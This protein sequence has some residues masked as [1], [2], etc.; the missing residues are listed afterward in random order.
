[1]FIVSYLL[2]P[3]NMTIKDY[4]DILG[5]PCNSGI[6][7]IKK[8][9]R[10]KAHQYHPDINHSPGAKDKF[11]SVTEAYEFLV[12]YSDKLASDERAYQQAMEDWR[13][14][15]QDRS[16]M[17]ASS[18]AHASYS[19]FRKTKLYKTTRIFDGTRII[20]SLV[21]SVLV[22]AYSIYGYIYRLHHPWN[23]EKPSVLAFILLLGVGFIFLSFS[24]LYLLSWIRMSKKR[25]KRSGTSIE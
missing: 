15:R 8:A 5:I 16:R 9:Y 4:Y 21:I 17:R 23:D 14:Y 20:Y 10:K 18:Y 19:S 24:L 1:M 6:D 12:S 7:E 3:V 2:T 25:K 11:I 13:K 22:I